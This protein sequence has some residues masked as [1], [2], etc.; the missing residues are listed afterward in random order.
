MG[1]IKTFQD[2]IFN[3][4]DKWENYIH[5]QIHSTGIQT[6]FKQEQMF[7]TKQTW[8][9]AQTYSICCA[10]FLMAENVYSTYRESQCKTDKNYN[11]PKVKILR[12]PTSTILTHK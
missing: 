10:Y 6:T 8:N 4:P 9:I 12:M 7:N 1:P 3:K 11:F 2:T 5:P